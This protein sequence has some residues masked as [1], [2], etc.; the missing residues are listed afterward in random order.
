[1]TDQPTETVD[2]PAL[3]QVVVDAAFEIWAAHQEKFTGGV[4]PPRERWDALMLQRRYNPE[5]GMPFEDAAIQGA[6]AAMPLWEKHFVEGK[7]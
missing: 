5:L 2:P 3:P 7:V 6:Q 1:M 4:R